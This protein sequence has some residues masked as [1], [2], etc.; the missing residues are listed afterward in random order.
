[1]NLGELYPLVTGGTWTLD[2]MIELCT[3][4]TYDLDGDGVLGLK[5]H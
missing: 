3:K 2:K 4:A 1:M 5:D